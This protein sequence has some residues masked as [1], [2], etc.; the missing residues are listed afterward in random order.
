MFIVTK[1]LSL[2]TQ[3]LNWVVV[4]LL[5]GWLF[6]HRQARRARRLTL[7]ALLVLLL[8][9]WQV[10]PEALMRQLEASSNEM[11]PDADLSAYAGVVVLGGGLDASYIAQDHAQPELNGSAERMTAA[12]ALS[13]RYPAMRIL[14]TGGEGDLIASGPSEAQRARQFFA[15]MGLPAD[16]LLLEGVSRNTFENATLSA[17]MPGVNVHQKWLLVTSAWH[18]RRSLATFRKAGWNV[19]A[20]P[21]DFRTGADTP[22]TRYSIAD[23]AQQWQLVLHEYLGLLAYWLAGRL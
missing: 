7:A 17:Q 8:T 6:G 23:G 19:T 1:L 2:L 4:L 12:V 13:Q 11:A 9:G 15:A 21:V 3:P 20:Y 14:F 10:P 16:R 18:M 5:A 22:W